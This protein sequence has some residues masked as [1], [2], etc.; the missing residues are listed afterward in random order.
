MKN[1]IESKALSKQSTRENKLKN[2]NISKNI[3]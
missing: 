1:L 2:E 3:N